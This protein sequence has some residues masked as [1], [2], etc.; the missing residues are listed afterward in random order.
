MAKSK[1]FAA[2]PVHRIELTIKS[3]PLD[4]FA[5]LTEPVI[6]G[7]QGTLS[8]QMQ[9]Q[10]QQDATQPLALSQK[11]ELSLIGLQLHTGN[12]LLAQD[13]L[14]WKGSLN[15]T[16]VTKFE[17]VRVNGAL[18]LSGIHVNENGNKAPVASLHDLSLQMQLQLQQNAAEQLVINQKGEL[19]LT[20]LQ[21]QTGNHRL[22]QDN[23][24]WKG[25]LNLTDV[26]KFEIFQMN[27][28]LK[29][30]GVSVNE[31]GNKAPVASLHDLSLQMQLLLQQNAAEQLAI[32][33][34]GEL[35]LTGLQLQIDN[36]RLT[37][38]ELH[39]DGSLN[40]T[41]IAKFETLRVNGALNLA[42]INL[43]ETGAKAPAV[44][45]H[46]L[47]LTGLQLEGSTQLTLAD[48]AVDS[49]VAEVVRRRSGVALVGMPA[50]AEEEEEAMVGEKTATVAEEEPF[51]LR[52]ERVRLSGEN[53]FTFD[54]QT[55]KPP[56][57]HTITITEGVLQHI[58]TS[59]PNQLTTVMIKGKDNY[60]TKFSV[61]GNTKPFAPQLAFDLKA[62]L[63]NF[64][65]PPTSPYLAQL[66]GYRITTGQVDSDVTMQVENN[67]MK[68]EVDLR[69]NQLQLE[70][71]DP[72]RIEEFQ[73]KST[74]PLN[75]ALSLLRDSND[76]IKLKL[77][78]S[79]K[80]DDPQFDI[81]DIINTALG[82]SLKMASVSYL[83]MLLQPYG[84]LITI[85]QMAGKAAGHIQL[86]PVKFA[87]GSAEL[88]AE[89]TP[90]IE[91]IS[92]L[93]EK[94]NIN[95]QLCGFA[96]VADLTALTKGKEKVIPPAGHPALEAL[97]KQRAESI[98]LVLVNTHGVSPK[99][100]F[101]CHPELDSN[102]NAAAR[103][104]ISI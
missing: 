66:L 28:A 79:G 72:A 61:D 27:G 83:K 58:D 25:S 97:A 87:A 95:M 102:E 98:K 2:E 62:K 40:L 37:Q 47:A 76:N 35:S 68:G 18:K 71:E 15:L 78:I 19:S 4:N 3:L 94:K 32:S 12:H 103:V 41:D 104:E 24:H 99:Q 100:L 92:K 6:S 65:M 30:S 23:L 81:N 88:S 16:D 11:G 10:L 8:S 44:S 21:L 82:K 53:R 63:N 14:H 49:L 74:L 29:L 1:P 31:S 9:L 45:L 38:D 77:P 5:K 90:Y 54:D 7:L 57:R 70:P 34:K 60:Y 39:W 73:S 96:T 93:L 43:S 36:H 75:T 67:V 64:D 20:G 17:T 101:I 46:G 85:I 51:K 91:K 48:V 89:T 55:V 52:I 50:A 84:S 22:T 42:G 33:Q 26:T 86:D 56:F 13:G 59:Q 69:M 80:L